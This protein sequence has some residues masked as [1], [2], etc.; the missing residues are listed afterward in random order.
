M[1]SHLDNH[2]LSVRWLACRASWPLFLQMKLFY[3]F[4]VCT[5]SISTLAIAYPHDHYAK[6]DS[7][8]QVLAPRARVRPIRPVRPP[9]NSP[10]QPLPA[11]LELRIQFPLDRGSRNTHQELMGKICRELDGAGVRYQKNLIHSPHSSHSASGSGTTSSGNGSSGDDGQ[12]LADSGAGASTVD[13]S[14]SPDTSVPHSKKQ[15]LSPRARIPNVQS[16]RPTAPLAVSTASNRHSSPATAMTFQLT[17]DPTRAK[18]GPVSVQQIRKV[19]LEAGAVNPLIKCV[20]SGARSGSDPSKAAFNQ[21]KLVARGKK[22]RRPSRQQGRLVPAVLPSTTSLL[23]SGTSVLPPP[24]LETP[25][26]GNQSPSTA[27][28]ISAPSSECLKWNIRIDNVPLDPVTGM[29]TPAFI[30]SF[31]KDI[32]KLGFDVEPKFQ[33]GPAG[34]PPHELQQHSIPYDPQHVGTEHLSAGV[35]AGPSGA[36]PS[37]AG[38]SGAGPSGAGPSG[39]VLFDAGHSGAGINLDAL[40]S[41][42]DSA[43][44][45]GSNSDSSGASRK[46][47]SYSGAGPSDAGGSKSASSQR[48]LSRRG[49]ASRRPARQLAKA[50]KKSRASATSAP[51]SATLIDGNSNPTVTSSPDLREEVRE[52]METR[53]S[54]SSDDTT[55][56][57]MGRPGRKSAKSALHD[58]KHAG[59]S[60]PSGA[61][62]SGAGPSNAGPSGNGADSDAV[63]RYSSAESV[64]WESDSSTASSWSVVSS[65]SDKLRVT[66]AGSGFM[67][68]GSPSGAGRSKSGSSSRRLSRRGKQSRRPSRVAAKAAQKSQAS[69]TASLPVQPSPTSAFTAVEN[70]NTGILRSDSGDH[71]TIRIR[72]DNVRMDPVTGQ[73]PKD[74]VEKMRKEAA[75]RGWDLEN[76]SVGQ[77]GEQPLYKDANHFKQSHWNQDSAGAGPSG[78]GSSSTGSSSPG[79]SSG[80]DTSEPS[81]SRRTLSPRGKQSRRP[82]RIAAKAAHKDESSAL[83]PT[84]PSATT[85]PLDQPLVTALPQNRPPTAAALAPIAGVSGP[86]FLDSSNRETLRVRFDNIQL[87]P[88]S[89]LPSPEFVE[90]MRKLT[91]ETGCNLKNLRVGNGSPLFKGKEQ[92]QAALFGSD[93]SHAGPSSADSSG[94]GPSKPSSPRRKLSPRGKK[95]RRPS[96]IEGV[97]AQQSRPSAAASPLNLASTTSPRVGP[98]HSGPIKVVKNDGKTVSFK[99]N[100]VKFDKDG[101]LDPEFL[102]NIRKLSEQTGW[103]LGDIRV[104]EEKKPLYR[105]KWDY[106]RLMAKPYPPSGSSGAGSSEAGPSG[107]GSSHHGSSAAGPSNPHSSNSSPPRSPRNLIPRGKKSRRP[108]RVDRP[109]RKD[110]PATTS[111]LPVGT[112]VPTPTPPSTAI[113]DNTPWTMMLEIEK[114][115]KTGQPEPGA[116]EH[117]RKVLG[118]TG[119]SLQLYGEDGAPYALPLDSSHP[120]LDRERWPLAA[121]AGR[122]GAGLL[123]AGA[124]SA[125]ASGS[126]GGGASGSGSGSSGLLRLANPG[127][128]S[129]PGS[130]GLSRSSSKPRVNRRAILPR[131]MTPGSLLPPLPTG[132]PPTIPSLPAGPPPIIPPPPSG[133]PSNIPPPHPADLAT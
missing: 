111:A 95:S 66:D 11:I 107:P 101:N 92:C 58:S 106:Q 24:A 91:A 85:L 3:H 38:P 4:V 105:N 98:G 120:Q 126:S 77:N 6:P 21:R 18:L 76:L 73:P 124:L 79:D 14:S 71:E 117:I 2:L 130:R 10:D 121:N 36:G 82:S 68:V 64:N 53:L 48:K 67:S 47:G 52:A 57:L 46:G 37:G 81:S 27:T 16:D 55:A 42:I 5:L 51:P 15:K 133:P 56:R 72:F 84:Q 20:S 60:G 89:G 132:P 115:P 22:S 69:A 19:L 86:I 17:I 109:A 8:E 83:P 1:F 87:D 127:V 96:R 35:G 97:A 28:P 94:A 41:N 113:T 9:P 75:K 32:A 34:L 93:K 12:R 54:L 70:L 63:S 103:S 88:V 33:V 45:S 114:N 49:K 7:I 123:S 112:P 104:G 78:A 23:P 131:T 74:F 129:P 90:Y 65:P 30:E 43:E 62:S 122:S 25:I 128:G 61:S 118:E 100:D 116:M 99:F 40:S 108:T 102:E 59:A 13:G 80:S 26:V 119:G 29:P 31:R 125:G 39:A 110:R 44:S 50:L